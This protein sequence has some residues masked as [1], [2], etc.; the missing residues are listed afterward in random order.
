MIPVFIGW[1]RREAVAYHV[2]AHSILTR[3]SEPVTIAPVGNATL[4]PAA[5]WR[6]RGALDSTDFSNARFMVPWLMGF[7]GWAIFMDCDMLCLD[8]LAE[9]WNQ[10]DERFAVM[11][12]KHE[13]VPTNPTKFLGATQTRYPR[14]NWSSLMLLNCGH[15][16]TLALV[17]RFVN[18]AAGL[19]LHG[20]AWT[21]N[22][23][24]IVGPWNELVTHDGREVSRPASLVHYTDGG[25]WHGY[26]TQEYAQEWCQEADAMLAEHNPAAVG[27]YKVRMGAGAESVEVGAT[28]TRKLY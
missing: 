11:V 13:H 28:F 21:A 18:N 3:S 2:L 12:R 1:D 24:E 10:R 25:P 23:G 17:P 20:F 27:S 9:L 16:D 5:W 4:P 22:I 19:D 6:Q 8:D 26:A 7:S 14:K 15:P